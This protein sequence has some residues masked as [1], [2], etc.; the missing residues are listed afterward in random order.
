MTTAILEQAIAIAELNDRL[1][2]GDHRLGKWVTS[3]IVSNSSSE[4][5][6][7]LFRLVRTFDNFTPENDPYG[8][9]DFGSVEL[10]EE[11]YLWKIDYYDSKFEYGSEDPSD[12]AQ[13]GR[14]LT[15]MHSSEY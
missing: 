15:I 3:E 8:E 7:E 2:R 4:E 11:K 9:R 6:Q 10:N 5:Q 1:R 13:T 14:V 12:P